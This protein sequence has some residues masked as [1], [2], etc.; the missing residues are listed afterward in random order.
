MDKYENWNVEPLHDACMRLKI[1][2]CFEMNIIKPNLFLHSQIRYGGWDQKFNHT[3][4]ILL[5]K[6]PWH[7]E[8]QE[9]L[10]NIY[11]FLSSTCI[12]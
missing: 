1:T 7:G 3:S 11:Y 10:S 9:N 6:P 5:H 2:F 4:Y 8:P 12:K